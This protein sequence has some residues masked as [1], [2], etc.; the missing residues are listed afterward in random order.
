MS[1]RRSQHGSWPPRE[2]PRFVVD[3]ISSVAPERA[4]DVAEVDGDA[5]LWEALDLDSVD[6]IVVM[7][8]L[9]AA[10]GSDIA[11]RDLP[12]LLTLNQLVEYLAEAGVLDDGDDSFTESIELPD[13]DSI[14]IRTTR[15]E[16]AQA[17]CELY[18]SLPADDLRLRFFSAFHPGLK[19]CR[20]WASVADRGGFG[21]IAVL[22]DQNVDGEHPRD[23]LVAEAGYAMRADGDGDLAVTVAPGQRGWLGSYLVDVLARHAAADGIHN[24][25][26]EILLENRPMLRILQHSGAVAFEH[27]CGTVRCS[28]PTA[29]AVS[30]WPP[31]DH[32]PRVLVEVAGGRWSGENAAHQAG[33]NVVLCS[34][35]S[36]RR[37]GCPALN[38]QR[39]PLV[40]DADVIVVALD[41]DTPEGTELIAHHLERSPDTPV[42]VRRGTGSTKPDGCVVV[43]SFDDDVIGNVLSLASERAS[44]R[45]ET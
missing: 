44:E 17:M 16:D 15:A 21:V 10:I 34:G 35:P 43:D 18:A 22:H 23:R 11:D 25:Q 13:G 7:E 38:R 9:S 27:A 40:D 3:A 37:G 45:D 36:R 5:D 6:H 1:G 12:R 31:L 28:I 39:C 4:S 24:L 29:G 32:R 8:Q 19:W 30:G 33:V 26:A 14:E 2:P 20:E 42:V 41:P